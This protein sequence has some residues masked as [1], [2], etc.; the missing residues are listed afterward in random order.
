MYLFFCFTAIYGE[1]LFYLYDT[2]YPA[3]CGD[4]KFSEAAI[5]GYINS[6]GIILQGGQIF[7]NG[8][9]RSQSRSHLLE[10]EKN[11]SS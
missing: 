1:H 4:N 9:E 7:L 3:V 2:D 10:N 8:I 6:L 11:L 5:T